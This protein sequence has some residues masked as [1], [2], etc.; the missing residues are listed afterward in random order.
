MI[1]V[2]IYVI[3][4]TMKKIIFSLVLCF[5][6]FFVSAK[7]FIRVIPVEGI[8]NPVIADFIKREF[9]SI[10]KESSSESRDI[11]IIELDTPGGLLSSTQEIVK[12]LLNSSFPVVVYITPSGA[13]AASAGVFIS[14]AANI[15][16]MAP[17][18]HLGAAHPV[19]GGGRWGNL[20][21]EMK[22]K[23]INDTLAWAKTIATTRKRPFSFIKNAVEKSISITEKEA[24]K[25][26]ICDF[27]AADLNEVIKKI[28][29]L[30]VETKKGKI[31][32]STQGA[33][34][35]YAS[36]NSYEKILN[37][38]INPNVAYLLFT[39]GFLGLIF[40]FTHP[41]FGF[42]GIF[43][44][45]CIIV[46]LYAF[47]ILPVNYAGAALIILGILFFVIEAFTPTF[48]LFTL[49][50]IISFV[51]GSLLLYRNQPVIELPLS[52]IIAVV[53]FFTL[54]SMFILTKTFASFRKSSKVGVD[55]L[56]GSLGTAYTD[57]DNKQGKVFIHG[58]LWNAH[59]K[60]SIKKGE[61][62]RVE[63]VEGLNLLVK[64][65][66]VV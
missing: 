45:I 31:K 37:I 65:K 41:G 47:S 58:E 27:V 29:G 39:L 57:I 24:L 4:K 32:I 3:L 2:S 35:S 19:L 23:I 5:L 25:A 13:R 34:V 9:N 40:E 64:R 36:L 10:E 55:A 62:V 18:T 60:E 22:E 7:T 1:F 48:G 53:S 26:R 30:L 44:V 63:K 15:L 56:I 28:D 49:G 21:K 66:E 17:Y 38:L 51:L 6:P 12:T 54:V 43:G 59:S 42:P 14:Y 16:V 50:G 8:I 46:S 11:V 20:D 61:E 52:T 33:S